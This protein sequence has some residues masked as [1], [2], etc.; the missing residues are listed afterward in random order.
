MAISKN[1]EFIRGE[2]RTI[3]LEMDPV[4]LTESETLRFTVKPVYDSD[5]TDKEAVLAKEISGP[6][7]LEDGIWTMWIHPEDTI[8]IEPGKYV[9]D[10]VLTSGTDRVTLLQGKLTIKPAATLRG[11]K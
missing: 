5:L 4:T 9:Y 3:S 6:A 8:E 10:L 11:V 1:I 7:E 2:T